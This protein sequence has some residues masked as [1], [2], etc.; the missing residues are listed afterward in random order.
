M[1][2]V[3]RALGL[4]LAVVTIFVGKTWASS[5]LIARPLPLADIVVAELL[6]FG[7]WL[8]LA[9]LALLAA[10]RFPLVGPGR[11]RHLAVLL[12]IGVGLALLHVVLAVLLVALLAG[13]WP[14]LGALLEQVRHAFAR[15][16][17]PHLVV[18]AALVAVA[19]AL[20]FRR[21]A[22]V[23]ARRA[24]ALE[25]ALARAERDRLRMQLHP[26][27][28]FNTLHAVSALMSRD[29]AG[30]RR[31]IAGL[32]ELLRVA[33]DDDDD[34]VPLARELEI[35]GLY[36]EIQQTR[37]A[38]R[39]TITLDVDPEARA[40]RVPKLLLQPLVENAIRHGIEP[41]AGGGA[42]GLEARRRGDRLQLTLHDDG[43]GLAPVAREGVGLGNT[44]ARLEKSYPGDHR[45][46]LA[47]R[48]GGGVVATIDLPFRRG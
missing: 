8:A 27:F 4:W 41:R 13:A 39:L 25:A 40:A 35:L 16:A 18:Y 47:P 44:R 7:P 31:M 22:E 46:S 26:H 10:R 12:V 19:H 2:P 36:L 5:Q 28:L 33:L 29:V 38:E 23:R 11:A 42:L 24:A 17:G 15:A 48:P 6:T 9:P 37:F 21:D 3:L 30:A 32:S 14:S 45:F 1:R 34:D 43:A 20:A